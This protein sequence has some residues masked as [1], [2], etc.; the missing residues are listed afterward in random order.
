MSPRFNNP[1]TTSNF[2]WIPLYESYTITKRKHTHYKL[3]GH[4]VT[5]PQNPA[6]L[7]NVLPLPIYQL[8]DYF[9]VVFIGKGSPSHYQLKKVLQVQK[10]IVKIALLWLFAHNKL[11]KD[12][13]KLDKNALNDLPEGEIP[14]SLMLTTTIVDIDS[15]ETEHYTG[16]THDPSSDCQEFCFLFKSLL[17]NQIVY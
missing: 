12:K 17:I 6:S 3:R 9:K 10:S 7:I 15:Q 11:F 2:T 1:R 8:C 5:F 14:K 4:V 13:F 16:Y